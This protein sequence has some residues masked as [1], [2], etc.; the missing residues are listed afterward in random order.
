VSSITSVTTGT[1]SAG[2]ASVSGLVSGLDTSALIAAQIAQ[3]SAPQDALKTQV[4]TD[5]KLLTALQSLNTSY[6]SLVTQATE[7]AAPNAWN[8]FTTASS[9]PSVSATTTTDA[10]AGSI[11]F[12]IN[13][14]ATT[15]VGVTATMQNFATAPVFTI[16]GSDG[17]QTAINPASGN[18]S[19]IADAINKSS[20][21]VSAIA[22]ASGKDVTTGASLYRLQLSSKSSGAAG[23]FTVYQGTPSD[24]AAGTATN[25]LTAPGAAAIQSASD[26]SITLWPGTAAAQTVTSA[27]NTLTNLLPGV[28][29]TIS[30]MTANP[31]TLTMKQDAATISTAASYLIGSVNTVLQSIATNSA[32]TSS[33]DSS[34][35]VTTS[36]G[37]FAGDGALRNAATQLFNTIAQLPGGVS[38][39][40]IGFDINQDGTL[41]FDAATFKAALA[42]DP[43]GTQNLLSQIA[44]QVATQAT[45]QSDPTQGVLTSRISTLTSNVTSLNTQVAAWTTRLASRQ[46][47]LEAQYSAMESQLGTLKTQ[48]DWLNQMFPTTTSSASGSGH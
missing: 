22:V 40:S 3:E 37:P 46:T 41:S 47:Q 28:S 27:N 1:N 5:N 14:V 4:A 20:A 31:V 43:I 42:S 8:V 18:I 21:G 32:I 34:G 25:I 17:T 7:D 39:A 16:V 44:S 36:G 35:N 12:S 15:Q 23:D 9:D 11:T 38:P 10:S 48:S 2:A 19:D 6:A 33:T 24:V 30:A 29:V 26:A 45:A 13:S